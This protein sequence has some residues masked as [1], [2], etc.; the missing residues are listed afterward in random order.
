MSLI[1]EPMVTQTENESEKKERENMVTRTENGNLSKK[2]QLLDNKLIINS[3]KLM[4]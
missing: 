1:F 3:K 4:I 2:S